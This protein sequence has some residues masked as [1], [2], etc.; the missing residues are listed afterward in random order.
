MWQGLG[1]TKKCSTGIDAGRRLELTNPK[2]LPMIGRCRFGLILTIQL[3]LQLRDDDLTDN[4][5]SF[6]EIANVV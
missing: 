5:V 4:C 1:R 2:A 3:I 6:V